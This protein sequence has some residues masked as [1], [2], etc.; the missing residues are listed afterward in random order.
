M[1]RGYAFPLSRLAGRGSALARHVIVVHVHLGWARRNYE[2]DRL[3]TRFTLVMRSE[4]VVAWLARTWLENQE[5]HPHG[6]VRH[7][8]PSATRPAA[9]NKA[10]EEPATSASA[11][12]SIS[13][14]C[15]G[16]R[17]AHSRSPSRN[18]RD[19]VG[20][21]FTVQPV[22]GGQTYRLVDV[23]FSSGARSVPRHTH[24]LTVSSRNGGNSFIEVWRGEPGQQMRS[25]VSKPTV[26]RR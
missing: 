7:R 19:D 8:P 13:V 5:R 15:S 11:W 2:S 24:W 10:S 18:A 14:S 4:R 9:S 22:F 21:V 1:L 16:P 20:N 23:A 3:V 26:K 12:C 25:A 17:A 6:D